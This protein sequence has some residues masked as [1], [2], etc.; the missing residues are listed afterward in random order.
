MRAFIFFLAALLAFSVPVAAQDIGI[1]NPTDATPTT[2][3]FHL[4]AQQDF[5]INT[6]APDD[7][8]SKGSTR[9]ILAPTT[10]CTP[11]A[12][13]GQIH[14]SQHTLYGFSTPGYV[15]YDFQEDG[16]PRI[17]PERGL[18]S[19]VQ[20]DTASEM[21]GTFY[22]RTT[23][24]SGRF[25][26]SAVPVNDL[27]LL[28]PQVAVQF[29]MRTGDDLSFGD[30][31]YN[32]GSVIAQGTSAAMTLFPDTNVN[33]TYEPLPDGGHLYRFDVP[34][35]ISMDAIPADESYN[36]RV[37]IF[38]DIPGCNTDNDVSLMPGTVEIYTDA[39]HRPRMDFAVLNALQIVY[40]HP[41][42]VGNDLYIHTSFNSPWGNYDIDENP[43]GIDVQIS[44]P[45]EARSLVRA[46]FTQRHHEH[47]HHFEPV[48]VTYVWPYK[49]D[50]A[51]KG[52]YTVTVTAQ[53]DQATALATGSARVDLAAQLA[54][55]SE[56]N[57]VERAPGE[58]GKE[59]PGA[60]LV[61]VLGLLAA[62]LIIRR[63]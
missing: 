53:N 24:D 28:V 43:G 55:D 22:L 61:A 10:T 56:G 35:G 54:F 38:L 42:F 15:E 16:G 63:K 62:A 4:D 46:A 49:L 19:D 20:L 14:Q 34:M 11:E 44:G 12:L 3:F 8:Y 30:E 9:G 57:E 37:D 31:K 51:E 18:A 36:V 25:G 21:V 17:H 60:G 33:P 7:R 1:N 45:S 48:D 47:D 13:P 58:G 40:I 27:P 2:L 32:D 5:P 26:S 52:D 6:Q 41:Q 29:T 39:D 50:G 23:L 59:S